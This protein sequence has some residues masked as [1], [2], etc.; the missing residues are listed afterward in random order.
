MAS[1]DVYDAS[2]STRPSKRIFSHK[3]ANNLIIEGTRAHFIFV[4]LNEFL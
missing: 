2:I 3:E 1:I 4:L